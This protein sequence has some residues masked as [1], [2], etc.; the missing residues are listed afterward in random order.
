MRHAVCAILIGLAPA[1]VQ[2]A[3]VADRAEPAATMRLPE[4]TLSLMLMGCAI[5]TGG[6]AS[7]RRAGR[8]VL[9]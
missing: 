7:R 4:A 2:A 5:V 3:V 1:A 9:S 6:H 8:V